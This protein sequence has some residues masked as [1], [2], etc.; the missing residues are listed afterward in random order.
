MDQYMLSFLDPK[1]MN[2]K[3][4]AMKTYNDPQDGHKGRDEFL[5]GSLQ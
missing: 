1:E 2:Q 4:Q 3:F 5:N